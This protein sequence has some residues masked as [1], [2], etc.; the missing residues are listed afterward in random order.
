MLLGA[1]EINTGA[2]RSALNK[3][4]AT[5][6]NHTRVQPTNELLLEN[7][8]IVQ[9]SNRP[10][11][12]GRG[13]DSGFSTAER[14][15]RH[16]HWLDQADR[17]NT[18]RPYR[19]QR[20]LMIRTDGDRQAL[21]AA[22][23]SIASNA[24]TAATLAAESGEYVTAVNQ[25]LMRD[26]SLREFPDLVRQGAR[27]L[28]ANSRARF[29]TQRDIIFRIQAAVMATLLA[30][31]GAIKKSIQLAILNENIAVTILIPN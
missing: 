3:L 14:K 27:D 6:D 12:Q 29:A 24:A 15:N 28:V 21:S 2:V 18:W 23:D 5:L 9:V 7:A 11:T 26:V 1:C 19:N 25:I 16:V 10:S 4:A 22:I 20:A 17:A 30:N 13:E 31:P 8:N